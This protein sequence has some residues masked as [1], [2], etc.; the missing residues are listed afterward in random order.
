VVS[1]GRP[2]ALVLGDYYIFGEFDDQGGI[3][4]LVRRFDI[5][6][7]RDLEDVRSMDPAAA[8][9]YV[10]LGLSYLPVGAGQ[11]LAA[12][13]PLLRGG[14]DGTAAVPVIAASQLDGRAMQA[15][16]L[17]YLGYFSGLGHLRA[18]TFDGS[19]FMLGNSYD[20]LV[21]RRT[22]KHYLASSHLEQ[23]DLPGE[24]YALVTGFR[25]AAGN[26][27]IVIAGTRDA[28]LAQ[29]AQYVASPAGLDRLA[30]VAADGAAFEALLA[31]R[32][33]DNYGLDTRVIVAGPRTNP[34]WR[35]AV[36]H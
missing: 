10:D 33:A 1:G 26:R 13:A 4:K 25:A 15:N 28:A 35:R 14:P 2:V 9:H 23:S 22:G 16:A 5:N 12:V 3:G 27:V 30:T 8:S 7:P 21:D 31:I 19:R 24:D 17:V 6:A 29:A 20:E 18:P 11:A 32:V 34:Q 36:I